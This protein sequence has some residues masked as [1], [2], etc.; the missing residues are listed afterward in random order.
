MKSTPFEDNSGRVPDKTPWE[1]PGGIPKKTLGLF[2][3]ELLRK[4]F[5]KIPGWLIAVK[6]TFLAKAPEQSNEIP[7]EYYRRSSFWFLKEKFGEMAGGIL[8]N[9]R[10]NT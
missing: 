6:N 2:L 10:E 8:E 4:S 9:F 1:T 5:H 3:E 7:M